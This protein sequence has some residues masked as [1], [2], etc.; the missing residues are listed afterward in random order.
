MRKRK[1]REVV[2][3]KEEKEYIGIHRTFQKQQTQE[4]R[5]GRRQW[6]QGREIE[7]SRRKR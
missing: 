7:R 1:R 3:E 4:E 5:A 2:E 6:H